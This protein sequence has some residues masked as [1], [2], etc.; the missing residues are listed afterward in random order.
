M[1]DDISSMTDRALDAAVAEEIRE[2]G[3]GDE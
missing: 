2:K 3:Q 1:T